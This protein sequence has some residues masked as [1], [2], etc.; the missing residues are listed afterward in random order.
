MKRRAIARA[1]AAV[2]LAAC[3][4]SVAAGQADF[5]LSAPDGRRV[6][7]KDDGTW[8]YLPTDDGAALEEKK[9]QAVLA[10]ERRVERPNGCQFGVQLTN[11]LPY[12]IRTLVLHYSA[13]RDGVVYDTQAARSGF[14]ALR[15]GDRQ[16]R[17]VEF[18]GISCK[19]ISR[20]QVVGGDRC[21]MGDLHKFSEGTGMCLARVRVVQSD[22]VRFDK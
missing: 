16:F 15:P 8:R 7:L 20:L 22:L 18:T 2:L 1:A 5:T 9:E 11:N 4:A 6:L 3:G 21:V 14:A 19:E 12:P 17:H 13:Y 10:L